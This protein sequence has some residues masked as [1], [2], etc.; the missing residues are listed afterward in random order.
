[1]EKIELGESVMYTCRSMISFV[2]CLVS[3]FSIYD[4]IGVSFRIPVIIATWHPIWGPL[5]VKINKSL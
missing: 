1:M 2:N 5:A 3:N 4:T